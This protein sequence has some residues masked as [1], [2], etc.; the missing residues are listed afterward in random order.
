MLLVGCA[1]ASST[2]AFPRRKVGVIVVS[3]AE[4]PGPQRMLEGLFSDT[5]P[6]SILLEETERSLARRGW[7]PRRLGTSSDREAA[8][9]SA[10]RLIEREGL[11][12]LLLVTLERL[13]LQA[14]GTLARAE[15]DLELK[16]IDPEG[17]IR[18]TVGHRGSTN[19]A[20]YR[21]RND[22]TAHLRAALHRAL[23]EL[24]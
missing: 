21:A 14:V 16:L 5:E 23:R 18:W 19:V 24:P 9:A 2:D 22:W 20:L 6:G 15:V 1:H 8:E 7:Q 11:D 10:A 3:G 4:A 13:D 17:R 12:L